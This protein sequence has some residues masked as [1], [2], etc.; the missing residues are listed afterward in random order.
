MTREQVSEDQKV[1]PR[2][3]RH[4]SEP[5][6]LACPACNPN[7][8]PPMPA[9]EV[10]LL[11]KEIDELRAFIRRVAEFDDYTHDDVDEVKILHELQHEALQLL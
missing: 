1:C 4:M 7:P 2:G 3:G 5:H 9:E 11:F 6:R 8:R 10:D